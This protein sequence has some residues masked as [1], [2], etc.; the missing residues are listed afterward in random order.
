MPENPK[1]RRASVCIGRNAA[2]FRI[3]W[4]CGHPLGR[5]SS[6]SGRERTQP[7]LAH[8]ADRAGGPGWKSK[9]LAPPG[10]EAS[11]RRRLCCLGLA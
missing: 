11:L 3:F 6:R 9:P 5:A 1:G 8:K 4:V 10:S 2:E 7:G